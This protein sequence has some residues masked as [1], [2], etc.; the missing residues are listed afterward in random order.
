MFLQ[1]VSNICLKLMTSRY[2]I[3]NYRPSRFYLSFPNF[4]RVIYNRLHVL[5]DNQFG[6][7]TE[8]HSATLALINLYD[9]ISLALDR[10]ELAVHIFLDLSKA[11]DTVNHSFFLNIMACVALLFY[12]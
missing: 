7:T 8:N 6:F 4:E 9:K 2:S 1:I 10:D 5:C 11:F 3:T 12:G